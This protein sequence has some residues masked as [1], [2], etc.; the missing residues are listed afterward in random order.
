MTEAEGD[1]GV[2]VELVFPMEYEEGPV[3][4]ICLKLSVKPAKVDL[5][6]GPWQ[7]VVWWTGWPVVDSG[8]PGCE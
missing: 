8:D 1:G 2:Q 5:V 7:E 3:K 4:W 6:G